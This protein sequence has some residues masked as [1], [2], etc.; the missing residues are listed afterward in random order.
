MP[1]KKDETFISFMEDMPEF[2]DKKCDKFNITKEKNNVEV[3]DE[4]DVDTSDDETSLSIKKYKSSADQVEVT[5]LQKCDAIP[6]HPMRSYFSGA[7]GSGKTNLVTN[8]MRR[9]SYYRNFFDCIFLFSPT[10]HTDSIQ[11]ALKV[12]PSNICTDLDGV[13]EDHLMHILNVQKDYIKKYSLAKSDKLLIIFDDIL[14]T[15]FLNGP[16]FKLFLTQSR[17]YN[18]SLCV[19]SQK[20]VGVPRLLRLQFTDIFYFKGSN[21]ENMKIIEE[22]TPAGKNK[23]QMQALVELACEEPYSFLY[24][25]TRCPIPTR[26]RKNLDTYLKI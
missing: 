19:L 26:F 9:K 21:S 1:K 4:S 6:R 12:P 25:N 17:H 11:S 13:G 24:I 5:H 3:E 23:K 18:V 14:A 15:K 10:A 22:Y 2:K 20:F 16:V 8:L 7:S